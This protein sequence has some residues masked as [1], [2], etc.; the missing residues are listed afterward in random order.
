M[1]FE[2]VGK[3]VTSSGMAP[4]PLPLPLPLRS[5]V[6]VG[7]LVK[8]IVIGMSVYRLL[9]PDTKTTKRY[10]SQLAVN[11]RPRR[12]VYLSTD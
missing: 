6:S 5:H 12:P 7:K 10:V 3:V 11:C 8:M 1:E 4:D 2:K 9:G